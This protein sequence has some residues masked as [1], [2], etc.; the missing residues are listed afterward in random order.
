MKLNSTNVENNIF[1]KTRKN[2]IITT[3]LCVI[4]LPIIL[5]LVL[6][7]VELLDFQWFY[8]MYPDFYYNIR[9]VFYSIY[10][11][12]DL[13]IYIFIFIL[14]CI[15]IICISLI[16]Y[17]MLK[18]S[19]SYITELENAS[20][21]LLDKNVDYIQLRPELSDIADKMNHLKLEAQKNERLAKESEQRKNDLIV[22]LAHD[23]KTPLTSII[24]Y[25]ELLRE[26]PDL[27]IEQRVK[28][29]NITLDKAYRLEELM[30]EFFEIARFNDTKIVLMKKNLNLKLMLE[31][32]I[33]EFYPLTNDQNKKII[34][35]CDNNITCYADPDK[36]SRVFNNVIKNAISYSFENTNINI[37]VSYT[38]D[39]ITVAIQNEGYTIPKEKLDSIFEKFYRV[40]NA[41]KTSTGGAGLG[42]AI[43]KEIITLHGGNI[44]AKSE[45]NLTT[46][47]L[48]IPK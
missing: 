1:A 14:W 36:L 40:D 12:H 41:R 33:D 46:F 42:L 28:Y 26:S 48:N 8:D 6:Y 39:L 13:S 15:P 11:T 38:N 18:K 24:G 35:N 5:F 16:M 25:L 29:T 47:T 19:F 30:N 3:I 20:T 21:K 4:A 9:N 43:A 37:N 17:K 22:Y 31:Q 27:P 44:T 7:I 2:F 23:L 32:I 10:Y 45:N 34:I